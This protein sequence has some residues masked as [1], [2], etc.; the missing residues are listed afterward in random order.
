MTSLSLG[1]LKQNRCS[2]VLTISILF[3]Q[4][5][6]HITHV[7]WGTVSD[8]LSWKNFTNMAQFWRNPVSPEE[9]AFCFFAWS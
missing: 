7:D 4:D 3:S 8:K 6:I 5:I 2:H 9:T 1:S